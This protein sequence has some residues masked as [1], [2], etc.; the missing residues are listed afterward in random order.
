MLEGVEDIF[1][2]V[3]GGLS[4]YQDA[5]L[6]RADYTDNGAGT[7]TRNATPSAVKVQV[8]TLTQA[9]RAEGYAEDDVSLIILAHAG[10]PLPGGR[11]KDDDEV[12]V[13]GVRY[14]IH[15][16]QLDP[17]GTHWVCRGRRKAAA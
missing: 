14:A 15:G 11:V 10:D 16:P 12:T 9:Q 17:L 5:T 1:T 3:F 13:D 8:D 6:S 7:L 2:S 4:T